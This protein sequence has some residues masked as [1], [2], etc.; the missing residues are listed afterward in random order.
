M[1][2]LTTIKLD[3]E[4]LKI[5]RHLQR[6]TGLFDRIKCS[7][8]ERKTAEFL[9]DGNGLNQEKLFNALVLW[10]KCLHIVQQQK[11]DAE[12]MVKHGLPENSGGVIAKPK[13]AVQMMRESAESAIADISKAIALGVMLLETLNNNPPELIDVYPE[14]ETGRYLFIYTIR[15]K[16]EFELD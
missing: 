13:Q 6:W 12:E 8:E 15:E 3:Q 14:E 1:Q 16:T 9:F 2:L 7:A 11:I 5:F 4:E 10:K